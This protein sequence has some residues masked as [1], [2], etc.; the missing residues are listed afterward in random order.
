M[1]PAYRSPNVTD[2]QCGAARGREL[3]RRHGGPVP[4]GFEEL[5]CPLLPALTE[6]VLVGVR[7]NPGSAETAML[8][9]LNQQNWC[10]TGLLRQPSSTA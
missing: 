5:A 3:G 7:R 9:Q 1:Y 4:E 8:D 10:G 2:L 6:P